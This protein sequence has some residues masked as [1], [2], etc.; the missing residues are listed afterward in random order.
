L[1]ITSEPLLV[2]MGGSA[3]SIEALQQLVQLLP[4]T[5]PISVLIVV[6]LRSSVPLL[7]PQVLQRLSHL[8]VVAAIDGAA[9]AP[10]HI[11]VAPSDRHLVVQHGRMC[12]VFGPKENRF[13]PAIDPLFRT[14]AQTYG[15]RVIGVLL[16]GALY[17]GIAGLYDLKAQ[18]GMTIVQDPEEALIAF[19]PQH[20]LQQVEVDYVL[21]VAQIAQ[22]LIA[23]CQIP[24]SDWRLTNVG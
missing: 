1:E 3:G 23:L 20:A 12:V 21:P 11:Y 14:A 10:G 16:S 15:D 6:H 13:R 24:V 17:D 4:A 9:I 19:L 5:L 22:K 8:Q 7:L 18:G 2:V